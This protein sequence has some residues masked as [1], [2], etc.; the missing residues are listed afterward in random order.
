MAVGVDSTL[1]VVVEERHLEKVGLGVPLPQVEGEG[2]GG[3]DPL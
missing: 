3:V 2:E 1:R